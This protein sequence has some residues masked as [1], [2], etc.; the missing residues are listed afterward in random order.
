MPAAELHSLGLPSVRFLLLLT[1]VLNLSLLLG[2]D[3]GKRQLRHSVGMG[4][5]VPRPM[6]DPWRRVPSG[7]VVAGC[8]ASKESWLLSF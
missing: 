2:V 4:G 6:Q 7:Q 3:A 5:P 1:Q 8:V